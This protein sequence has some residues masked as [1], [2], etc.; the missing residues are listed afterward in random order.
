MSWMLGGLRKAITGVFWNS[1]L[2]WVLSLSR[3]HL[4]LMIRASGGRFAWNVVISGILSFGVL[5]DTV[6]VSSLDINEAL[7]IWSVMSLGG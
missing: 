3:S 1:S 7:V 5:R 2:R 6:R 4:L